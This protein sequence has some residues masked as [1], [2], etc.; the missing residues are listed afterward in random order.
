MGIDKTTI[1]KNIDLSCFK[2]KEK[3]EYALLP[4]GFL[5]KRD[6]VT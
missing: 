1:E 2:K 4:S 3:N 6:K 5:R